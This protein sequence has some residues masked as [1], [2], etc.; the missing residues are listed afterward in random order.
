MSRVT[1]NMFGS[2]TRVPQQSS[3]TVAST[4]I[5]DIGTMSW[6]SVIGYSVAVLVVLL[7]LLLF[8]NYTLYP[9]FQLQPGG[10]GFI[11]IPFM[12]SQTQFWTPDSKPYTLDDIIESSVNNSSRSINWSMT[13]DISIMNPTLK[14][15]DSD[16]N[17]PRFRLL[18]NRGGTPVTPTATNKNDGSIRT[19]MTGHNVA[20]GLLKDTNDLYIS[21]TAQGGEE[22]VLL[23]NI[24]TQTPFRIGI[25]IMSN[26]VEVYLNGKL[27]QTKQLTHPIAP[28]SVT[29]NTPF[30]FQGPT[31]SP[32]NQ[33]ARLGNLMIWNQV[34][35]PSIIQYATP[36]LMQ[37]VPGLD[38]L[39]LSATA[40]CDTG[41]MDSALND[42]FNSTTTQLS[43]AAQS[44]GAAA[45]AAA[46][47]RQS[48]GRP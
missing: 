40:S 29:K 37:M 17:Q 42:L 19:V 45:V 3:Y 11:R 41:S 32:N 38:S 27:A 33:I 1:M 14:I 22:G 2:P 48:G 46:T 7:I 5:L 36:S 35:T 24:P 15:I 6:T 43:N 34:V 10:P 23:T 21:F 18:F 25:V 16:S 31:S 47:T 4:D 12:Q 28:I 13:L 30:A 39:S 26:Y 9:I 44:A 20:V 8:I